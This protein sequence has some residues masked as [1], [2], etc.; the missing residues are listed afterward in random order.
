[1]GMA[2]DNMSSSVASGTFVAE[3]E[4][5]RQTI[6]DPAIDVDAKRRAYD[7]IL[8]HATLLDPHEAGF[9]RAGVALKGALC[10]W[11]DY[12]LPTQH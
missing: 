9:W 11:L 6:G 10:A 4:E 7:T 12:G 8:R 2:I 1:M 3:V 5:F